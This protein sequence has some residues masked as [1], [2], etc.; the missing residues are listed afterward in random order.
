M[1]ETLSRVSPPTPSA[2]PSPTSAATV[3][4][5]TARG[6]CSR[7]TSTA[8]PATSSGARY[9]MTSTSA[10]SMRATAKV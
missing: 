3:S 10:T 9:S 2:S 8:Q 1:P 7:I 6:T 5:Q 4:H